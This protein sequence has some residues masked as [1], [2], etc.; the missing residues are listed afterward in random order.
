MFY[1]TFFHYWN[2]FSAIYKFPHFS[3]IATMPRFWSMFHAWAACKT[4]TTRMTKTKWPPGVMFLQSVVFMGLVRISFT[5]RLNVVNDKKKKVL[6]CSLISL[7]F[8]FCPPHPSPHSTGT[9]HWWHMGAEL[10][11]QT[12]HPLLSGPLESPETPWTPSEHRRAGHSAG[13]WTGWGERLGRKKKERPSCG[14]IPVPSAAQ[15]PWRA[16][17][18]KPPTTTLDPAPCFV[19]PLWLFS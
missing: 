8:C 9:P 5:H 12:H 6:L 11:W 4:E 10:S 17:A 13:I 14:V 7:F 3:W 16:S 15:F 18:G 1:H 19:W 2:F